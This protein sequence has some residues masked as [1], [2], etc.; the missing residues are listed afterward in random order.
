MLV[1]TANSVIMTLYLWHITAYAAAYLILSPLRL[2]QEPVGTPLWWLQ[3][4]VWVIGPA[5]V[6]A[7]CIKIFARVERPAKVEKSLYKEEK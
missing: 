5:I 4:L 7:G 2:G 3:R 6:L 1:I